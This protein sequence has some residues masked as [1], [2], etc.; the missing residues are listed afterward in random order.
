[1]GLDFNLMAYV[2]DIPLQE[3]RDLLDR[4]AERETVPKL[5]N[6]NR[7]PGPCMLSAHGQP[8][9]CLR[10]MGLAYLGRRLGGETCGALSPSLL[11]VGT[12]ARV[13]FDRAK[14]LIFAAIVA[15]RKAAGA[16]FL[17]ARGKSH[18][19]ARHAQGRHSRAKRKVSGRSGKIAGTGSTRLRVELW[20][21]RQGTKRSE[22]R[23][24]GAEPKSPAGTGI[25]GTEPMPPSF[26]AI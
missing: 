26:R 3:V 7:G 21:P 1:V 2:V 22:R 15:R 10:L 6:V 8:P 18:R 23:A 13:L 16:G 19:R 9:L 14:H 11:V 20:H 17:A 12:A 5:G 24:T 4:G 25:R